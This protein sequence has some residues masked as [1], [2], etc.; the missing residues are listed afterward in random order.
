MSQFDP[1]AFLDT[2]TTEANDTR[3]IP[4]PIGEWQGTAAN[5]EIKSGITKQ[6]ERAGEPW[7][8][9]NVKWEIVGTEANQAVERDK[10]TVT[11]GIMLDLTPQGGLDVGRGKNTQLGRLREAVGLNTPGQPFSFRMI[12][13]RSAK[14][15]VVHRES[16]GNLYDD[17]KAALPI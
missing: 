11:Q 12:I 14:L 2:Q 10:I 17:V 6:G 13:G 1:Q 4:C 16:E 15:A 5:V 7:T 8:K 3:V 9:L